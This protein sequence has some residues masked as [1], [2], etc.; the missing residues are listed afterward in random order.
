MCGLEMHVDADD[1]VKLIRP[2]KNDVF[3]QG[4]ICPKGTTLGH[5]HEDPDRIARAAHPRRR[6]VP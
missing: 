5:L 2:Y 6:S 3:S 4:Y 1:K